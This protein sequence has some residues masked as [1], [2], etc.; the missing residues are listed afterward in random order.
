MLS[1]PANIHIPM[2]VTTHAMMINTSDI[3]ILSAVT[4]KSV[5][6]RDSIAK[7]RKERTTPII[8]Q[9]QVFQPICHQPGF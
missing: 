8:S 4:K 6:N 3:N 7:T 1:S 5:P 2:I 9:I